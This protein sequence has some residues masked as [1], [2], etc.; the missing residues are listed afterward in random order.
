MAR[1]GIVR[2]DNRLKS[3]TVKL[4]SISGNTVNFHSSFFADKVIFYR[5]VVIFLVKK[6]SMCILF[7]LHFQIIG[8]GN[9]TFFEVVFLSREEGQFDSALFVHTSKGLFKYHVSNVNYLY[10]YLCISR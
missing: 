9:S 2:I 4:I 10:L 6:L 3:E 7:L 5:K 8:P 1:L